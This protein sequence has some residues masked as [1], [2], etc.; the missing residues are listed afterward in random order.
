MKKSKPTLFGLVGEKA[1]FFTKEKNI[2]EAVT[3]TGKLCQFDGLTII[4][5][6]TRITLL[7]YAVSTLKRILQDWDSKNGRWKTR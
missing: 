6:E 7:P 2:Y 1:F 5:E 3:P 4:S